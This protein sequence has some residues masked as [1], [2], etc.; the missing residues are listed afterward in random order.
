MIDRRNHHIF[1]PLLNPIATAVLSPSHIA[2]PIRKLARRQKNLSVMSAEVDGIDRSVTIDCN[3]LGLK[4]IP[5][6]YL[7]LAPG[8]QAS[9]FG[10]D[11]FADYAP[12]L[13]AMERPYVPRLT[14][15]LSSQPI[16]PSA[17]D[18]PKPRR[19]GTQIRTFGAR[20]S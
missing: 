16:R 10:H 4:S 3:R 6:D 20:H 5:F 12:S 8:M 1:Q 11:E 9:Y 13:K 7:I 2:T 18:R 19:M 14:R 15:A 17:L